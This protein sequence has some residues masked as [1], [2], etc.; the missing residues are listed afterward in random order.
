MLNETIKILYLKE[1][2]RGV[3]E[4]GLE[5]EGN[6]ISFSDLEVHG[7]SEGCYILLEISHGGAEFSRESLVLVKANK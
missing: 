1:G 4:A 6:S 7:Q 5:N 2:R 3:I